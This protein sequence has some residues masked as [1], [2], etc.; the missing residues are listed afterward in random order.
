LDG[1]PL[2]ET[3]VVFQPVDGRPQ[4]TS[5]GETDAEG[6][7]ELRRIDGKSGAVVGPHRVRLTSLKPDA[8]DERTRLPPDRVPTRY[9]DGSLTFTVPAKGTSSADFALRSGSGAAEK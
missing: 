8:G 6:R 9:R 3:Q 2:G 1:E 4:D 7:Y 5:I